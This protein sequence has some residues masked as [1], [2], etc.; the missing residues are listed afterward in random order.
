MYPSKEAKRVA[1]LILDLFTSN[2]A[3]R[4]SCKGSS[5]GEIDYFESQIDYKPLPN[6]SHINKGIFY[7]SIVKIR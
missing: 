7:Y 4:Q 6:G 1:I 5:L 2:D 3:E